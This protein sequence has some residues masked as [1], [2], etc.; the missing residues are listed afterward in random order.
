M[1]CC[2]PFAYRLHLQTKFRQNTAVDHYQLTYTSANNQVRKLPFSSALVVGHCYSL[3]AC[4][5]FVFQVVFVRMSDGSIYRSANEGESW[6]LQTTPELMPGIDQAAGKISAFW[7]SAEENGNRHIYFLT[8]YDGRG[9]QRLWVTE[10]NGISYEA[11]NIPDGTAGILPHS[12]FPRRALALRYASGTSEAYMTTD[13]GKTWTKVTDD[14]LDLG[15]VAWGFPNEHPNRVYAII[16]KANSHWG[17]RLVRTDDWFQTT[18]T[19]LEH[20]RLFALRNDDDIIAAQYVDSANPGLIQLILSEDAGAHWHVAEFPY[21]GEIERRELGWSIY[22]TTEDSVFVG[23][24][25]DFALPWADIYKSDAYDRDF[26]RVLDYHRPVDFTRFAGLSGIYVANR[27]NTTYPFNPVREDDVDTVISFNKGASWDLL[28]PPK[29]RWSGEASD[30]DVKKGCSLHLHGF[31]SGGLFT[32]FYSVP[33]AVGLMLATGN[34][35]DELLMEREEVNTYISRDAGVTWDEVA[36]GPYVPEFGDSGAIIVLASSE[37][38]S[39][40]IKFTLD[41]GQHWTEC[42]IRDEAMSII[43][44]RVAPAWNSKQ[45]ILYGNTRSAN[46]TI[47]IV[48]GLEFDRI[49]RNCTSADYEEWSPV[50]EHGHCIL[51]EKLTFKRRKASSEC[52]NGEKFDSAVS[53]EPC[54]CSDADY[55]CDFCYR[56]DKTLEKCVFDCYKDKNQTAYLALLKP[57]DACKSETNREYWTVPGRGYRKVSDNA[58]DASKPNSVKLPSGLAFCNINRA[59]QPNNGNPAVIVVSLIVVLVVGV[60]IATVILVWRRGTS[61]RAWFG[62]PATSEGGSAYGRVVETLADED[63]EE[64]QDKSVNGGVTTRLD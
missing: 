48:I 44:I 16:G 9:T 43:N 62:G 18:T 22:D 64:A 13:T 46:G 59:V 26:S 10:N 53:R 52:W 57:D 27:W 61:I 14:L 39:N 37:V 50:D 36:P 30:C 4:V 40:T 60:V 15:S 56:F 5:L 19:V 2:A 3:I 12:I 63:E 28:T 54:L 11:R 32:W 1:A 35:G 25:R 6:Q 42:A 34:I 38:D 23:V 41:Q 45:F 31:N 51:G 24:W 58:C 29:K 17:N 7:T 49:A 55:E 20:V 33:N 47:P 21:Q 8:S